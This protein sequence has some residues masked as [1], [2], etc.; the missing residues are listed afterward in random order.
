M[1][2]RDIG[3]PSHA[4]AGVPAIAQ[5]RG[6]N[7]LK[8][9][10]PLPDVKSTNDDDLLIHTSDRLYTRNLDPGV[11]VY[12][13]RLV[14]MDGHEYRE[15]S[16][17]RSKLSSYYTLGGEVFPFDG[18]S[19]I[20]YLGAASGTTASHVSDLVPDG[21]VYCVEFS[22]RSF[23]DLVGVCGRRRNMVPILGDATSPE[24]FAFAV[25]DVDV[26]YQDVAQK[27]QTS[28]FVDNMRRFSA[29]S[30]FLC[31]KARSEDVSAD[32]GRIFRDSLS[33]LD[34]EGMRVTDSRRLDPYEKDHMMV[35]VG[36]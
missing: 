31:I 29:P 24:S 4:H 25:G 33:A 17:R 28:I 22:Q 1:L 6:G 9:I 12:G 5:R 35:A 36:T 15:W 11:R 14:M 27:R 20:L 19:R 26:V 7:T 21:I 2:F 16:P 3:G 34:R 32:P 30:G 18:D 13:E 23:R 10:C 8:P